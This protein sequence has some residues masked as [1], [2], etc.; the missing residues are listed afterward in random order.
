L[1]GVIHSLLAD[2]SSE[3]LAIDPRLS[4][5]EDQVRPA[6]P[7]RAACASVIVVY[8]LLI[9][10]GLISIADELLSI[11]E[12]LLKIGQALFLGERRWARGL[13]RVRW[14]VGL[15]AVDSWWI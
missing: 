8:L 9:D 5:V 1:L 11:A 7:C 4:I 14:H 6:A 12:G 10:A 3:L 2:V 13:I 15:L